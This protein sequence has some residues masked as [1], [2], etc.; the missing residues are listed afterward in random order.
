MNA[1]RCEDRAL[2]VLRQ[3]YRHAGAVQATAR[4]R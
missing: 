2:T 4:A 1:A 3:V